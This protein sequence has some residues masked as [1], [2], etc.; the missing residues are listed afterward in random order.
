MKLDMFNHFKLDSGFIGVCCVLF[1]AILWGTTGT[2]QGLLPSSREPVV[3][4]ALRVMIGSVSL[5]VICILT[6]ISVKKVIALPL[7]RILGAGAAIASYNM[8]FFTGVAHV[9]V[10]VG[11][12]IALGSGP[13]WV[14]VFEFFFSA[15]RP[16]IRGLLGQMAAIMG[17][18]VLVGGDA[19][20]QGSYMG[21]GWSGLAG[22][23]Y[24]TYVYLTRGFGKD[25]DS[26]LIA[27]ATFSISSVILFPSLILFSTVWIDFRSAILLIFLGLVATGLAF[28]L[29]TFGLKRMP[30]STAVTL[31]LVEPLTAWFLATIVL[32]EAVTVY[33]VVGV[34]TLIIGIRIVSRE[35]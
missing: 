4:A 17:L 31:S 23:A 12:A 27:A 1:A 24:G 28:L 15:R 26:A 16:S 19:Q 11:T 32:G 21:Y 6:G 9:G 18:A 30:A 13:L 7:G 20:G 35:L 33:K 25:I 3:V 22:L 10:G 2:I 34:V 29:F 8:F 5:W 14:L